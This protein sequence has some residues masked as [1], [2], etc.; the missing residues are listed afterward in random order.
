LEQPLIRTFTGGENIY[1]LEIEE[2]LVAYPSIARAIV[3]GIAH[4]KYVEL[5]VAFLELADGAEQPGLE[6]VQKWVRNV[7]GRHKAPTK[8][9]WLGKDFEDEVPLTGSGK[10]KKFELRA[11]AEAR[12]A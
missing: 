10:I 6:E 12:S 9:F 1:P 3:V 7:L 2:R 4:P 11:W 5:P 8:I